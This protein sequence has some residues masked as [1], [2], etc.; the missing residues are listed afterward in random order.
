MEELA[1]QIDEAEVDLTLLRAEFPEDL[2][3]EQT[4][5]RWTAVAIKVETASHRLTPV[6]LDEFVYIE[7][8]KFHL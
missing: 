5:F 2:S 8:V 6:Y 1:A 3:G 4:I 7:K